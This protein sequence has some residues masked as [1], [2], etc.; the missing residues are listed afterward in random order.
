MLLIS[1]EI[2]QFAFSLLLLTLSYFLEWRMRRPLRR[3]HK[4]RL[5]SRCDTMAGL[6]HVNDQMHKQS[7]CCYLVHYAELLSCTIMAN[8]DSI[9]YSL[10][11]K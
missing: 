2:W 5:L 10:P 6:Q 3:Y 1:W 8:F 9:P 11:Y 7:L 4:Y